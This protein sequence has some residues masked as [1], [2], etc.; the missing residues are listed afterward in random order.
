MIKTDDTDIFSEDRILSELEDYGIYLARTKFHY[1]RKIGLLPAPVK[2]TKGRVK[3]GIVSYY[4][5][6]VIDVLK[7]ID[8]EVNQGK[9]YKEI[10]E[11]IDSRFDKT[12][13]LVFTGYKEK[14]TE[15]RS[16]HIAK[17]S[18]LALG[19]RFKY[20]KGSIAVWVKIGADLVARW[21][22]REIATGWRAQSICSATENGEE[23]KVRIIE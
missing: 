23:I 3:S 13:S 10:K 15:K 6:E 4:P 21:D 22:K 8:K 18:S 9:T 14:V 1:L 19:T 7:I 12:Y 11:I 16:A 17:F 2:K 20:N 5:S